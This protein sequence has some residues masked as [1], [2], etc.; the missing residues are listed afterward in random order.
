MLRL[1]GLPTTIS[2]HRSLQC[3]EFDPTSEPTHVMCVALFLI[4]FEPI[5]AD[6]Y[7]NIPPLAFGSQNGQEPYRVSDKGISPT[8]Y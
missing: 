5:Y 7:L 3:R 8:P 4:R 1:Q 6:C 2:S